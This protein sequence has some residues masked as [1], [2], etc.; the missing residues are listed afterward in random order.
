MTR[1]LWIA[2][3]ENRQSSFIKHHEATWKQLSKRLTTIVRTPETFDAYINARKDF[4]LETKDVGSFVGGKFAGDTRRKDELEFRSVL[5]LDLDHLPANWDV[6]ALD[7]TYGDV[8]YIFHTTHK[9]S[10]ASPRFRLVFPLSRDVTIHEYEPLARGMA[11]RLGMEYFDATGF[12]PARVM[13]WPSA[14]C[15]AEVRY[16]HTRGPWLDP[17]AVLGSMPD[18]TDPFTWPLCPNEKAAPR[19]ADVKVEYAPGK[20]GVIGAFCRVFDIHRAIAEFDL[21]YEDT[22]SENRYTYTAGSSAQGA[23][24][25]D[26]DTQL[27]SHHESDPA[28]GLHNAWDLVRVHKFGDTDESNADMKALAMSI[29]EVVAEL[30]EPAAEIVFEDLTGGSADHP[31]EIVDTHADVPTFINNE[32]PEIVDKKT[33][34]EKFRDMVD[35]CQSQERFD[36]TITFVASHYDMLSP[37]QRVEIAVW[38]KDQY[39][40]IFPPGGWD[41]KSVLDTFK[42]KRALLAGATTTAPIDKM[43]ELARYVYDEAFGA[44]AKVRRVARKFWKYD[45]GLWY[46]VE[47]ETIQGIIQ[48]VV[49]KLRKADPGTQPLLQAAIGDK[50]SHI[51][52]KSILEFLRAAKAYESDAVGGRDPMMMMR[53]YALPVVNCKNCTIRFDANGKMTIHAHDPDDF[54]TSQLDVE[55]DPSAKCPEW[56]EFVEHV[57]SNEPLHADQMVRHLEEFGGYVIQYSRWLKIWSLF[58]GNTN[59]GKSTFQTVL[60]NMLGN[61]SVLAR[62]ADSDSWGGFGLNDLQGKLL[63]VDDDMKRSIT[64]DDGLLKKFSED[65]VITADVKFAS[66][67]T[68]VSRAFF[69]INSNHWPRVRDITEAMRNRAFVMPFAFDFLAAGIASD[70]KR[71]RMYNELPGI[72]NRFLKGISRLRARGHFDYPEPCSAAR[73]V[74]MSRANP[75]SHFVSECMERTKVGAVK[76]SAVYAA[77]GEWYAEE[78]NT[79]L[80][81]TSKRDVLDRFESA[82]CPAS[83]ANEWGYNGWKLLEDAKREEF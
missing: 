17:D 4:Q 40:T 7:L 41:K 71:L 49:V 11:S 55:Y 5:C 70:Q 82:I 79:R 46:P 65:R 78:Y 81:K 23:V 77:Y 72:L 75:V 42:N 36:E 45:A 35:A 51:A 44:G 53:T 33:T 43:E 14:S 47:D 73:D 22:S 59:T 60:T 16:D 63:I 50:E 27:F 64:L 34:M 83:K 2:V 74:W 32:Q 61:T 31:E 21:P 15:D 30:G 69:M 19:G 12:Q 67:N 6:G 26:F 56:D 10:A 18:Y 13:F 28:S 24:V 20:R 3:G 29:P 37:N 66:A 25:Y 8:E 39:N 1:K 52:A 80:N 68:F 62:A 9:H 57:F 58:Y 38:L 48:D 76:R 54:F